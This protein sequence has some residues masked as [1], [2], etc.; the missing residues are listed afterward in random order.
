MY[1]K[2]G[3]NHDIALTMIYCFEIEGKVMEEIPE[4]DVFLLHPI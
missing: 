4:M 3:S 1:C 2:M